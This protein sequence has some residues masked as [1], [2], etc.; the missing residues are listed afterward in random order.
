METTNPDIPLRLKLGLTDYRDLIGTHYSAH[1]THLVDK[2]ITDTCGRDPFAYMGN[3]IG[4]GAITVTTD[5]HVVLMRRAGWT[6]EEA[7]K[8][9]RPGGHPDPHLAA[10][11][12]FLR[13]CCGGWQEIKMCYW[14]HRIP[15]KQSPICHF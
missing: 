13:E 14:L 7:G 12:S 1:P 9:D 3:A 11:V 10:E 4:V 15:G 6:A 8:V 5:D 2:A